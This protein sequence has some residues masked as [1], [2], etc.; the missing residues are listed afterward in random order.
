MKITII[1]FV[2]MFIIGSTQAA[3]YQARYKIEDVTGIQPFNP[4]EKWLSIE[5]LYTSWINSGLV[6]DCNNWFPA[7]NI[8]KINQSFSQTATDCKQPQTRTRQDREQ[9]KY[10]NTIRN[11]GQPVTESQNITATATRNAI[12]TKEE[13]IST[14]PN[15]TTWTN[16]GSVVNCTNWSPA[17]STITYNQAFTQTATDCQQPQTRSRQER[18]QETTTNAIRNTGSPITESQSITAST[19]RVATGTKESWVAATPSYTAWTG[20]AAAV[21]TWTPDE[22]TVRQ[23]TKFIQTGTC[24]QTQTRTKQARE[25]EVNTNAYRNV[26]MPITE[27]QSSSYSAGT[28]QT[29]GTK[30][31][32]R[33]CQGGG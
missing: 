25:Q 3:E 1:P 13:W 16:N 23:G 4:A 10:S 26:G 7:E 8:I 30:F 28:R 27:T 22:S 5:S 29:Y 9:E 15:Y 17:T 14:T 21:C 12:G 6:T 33:V 31:C 24:T 20:S 18:E 19:T 2:A 32:D 11:I